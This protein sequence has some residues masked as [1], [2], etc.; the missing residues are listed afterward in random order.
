M[1][2]G[3]HVRVPYQGNQIS[4]LRIRGIMGVKKARSAASSAAGV[5]GDTDVGVDSAAV[6]E[7]NR[8]TAKAM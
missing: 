7:A 2:E 5:S 8:A 1:S 3:R 4:S 6:P